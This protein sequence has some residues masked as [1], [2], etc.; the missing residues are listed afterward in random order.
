MTT[1]VHRYPRV[2]RTTANSPQRVCT[3]VLG[4]ITALIDDGTV[5]A[6]GVADCAVGPG[7]GA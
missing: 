2:V 3:G 5:L 1:T 4:K 6:D 7:D